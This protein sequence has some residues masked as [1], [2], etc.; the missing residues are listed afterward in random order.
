MI[1]PEQTALYWS[2]VI[3]EAGRMQLVIGIFAVSGPVRRLWPRTRIQTHTDMLSHTLTSCLAL[4]QQCFID[5]SPERQLR[6][7]GSSVTH[8]GT[9]TW[10]TDKQPKTDHNVAH[11]LQRSHFPFLS[12]FFSFC[13]YGNNFP[14]LSHDGY[15]I[16]TTSISINQAYSCLWLIGKAVNLKPD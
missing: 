14:A 7:S 12:L 5:A 6:T 8:S 2:N 11:K 4:M 16:K 15:M 10:T 9:V 1:K 13:F 3:Y